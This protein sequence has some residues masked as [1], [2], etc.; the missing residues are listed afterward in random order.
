MQAEGLNPAAGQRTVA[1]QRVE[2]GQRVWPYVV[3]AMKVVT[4]D[5]CLDVGRGG[6]A[7]SR[8]GREQMLGRGGG[9]QNWFMAKECSHQYVLGGRRDGHDGQIFLPFLGLRGFYNRIIK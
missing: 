4:E 7:P 9:R 5:V 6:R 8:G 1:G 3:V 2:Q